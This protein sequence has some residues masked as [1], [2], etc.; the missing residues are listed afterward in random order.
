VYC[1][2]WKDDMLL[3][4]GADNKVYVLDH[5]FKIINQIL[6]DST[7]T[8]VDFCKDAGTIGIG[9]KNGIF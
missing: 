9:L 6:T 2:K 5:E 1:L 4:G 7:A 3:S 8:G